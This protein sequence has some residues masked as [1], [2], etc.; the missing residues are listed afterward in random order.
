[1]KF[2]EQCGQEYEP[3]VLR[4][5]TQRFC[6]PLCRGRSWRSRNAEKSRQ[7]SKAW[8]KRNPDHYKGWVASNND[9][10]KA[11]GERY[12]AR[13][14]DECRRRN[15]DYRDAHM[16]EHA[17]QQAGRKALILGVTIGNLADIAE[18]YRQAREDEPMRC[19]LCGELIELGDRH[20]DHKRP[21][22]KDGKHCASNLGITHSLCNLKKA[23]SLLESDK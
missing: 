7:H 12:Y 3:T 2:C 9:K 21:L 17:A 14:T 19:Y 8:R 15:Q 1:M 4:S 22:S 11:I 6:S 10:C 5:K 16:T 23:T 20:V 18:V 13:H